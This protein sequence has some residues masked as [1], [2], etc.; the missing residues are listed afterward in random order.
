MSDRINPETAKQLSR[1]ARCQDPMWL[2]SY[3]RWASDEKQAREKID[4]LRRSAPEKF[5]PD[6]TDTTNP[7]PTGRDAKQR[8]KR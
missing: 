1:K 3:L 5:A 7:R 4:R 2:F 8:R 6:T